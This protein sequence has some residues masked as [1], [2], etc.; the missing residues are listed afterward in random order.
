MRPVR[1]GPRARSLLGSP[2]NWGAIQHSYTGK[3]AFSDNRMDITCVLPL[4]GGRATHQ[5]RRLVFVGS[6]E[7]TWVPKTW[8][9]AMRRYLEQWPHSAGLQRLLSGEVFTDDPIAYV[10]SEAILRGLQRDDIVGIYDLDQV[11]YI[12]A[13]S[14]EG[15]YKAVLEVDYE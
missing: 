12:V 13:R 6:D 4:A 8:I 7:E 5:R 9:R 11:L 2:K 3:I 10:I 15:Q 14:K 1:L